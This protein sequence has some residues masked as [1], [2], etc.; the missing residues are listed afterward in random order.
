VVNGSLASSLMAARRYDDAIAQAQRTLAIEPAFAGAYLT[1]GQAHLQ[2]GGHAEAIAALEQAVSLS[3]GLAR[4]VAWL[5]HAY[6]VVGD[7]TKARQVL[8]LLAD[9]SRRA[10]VSPYDVA[11]VHAGLRDT[12]QVFA[13]LQRA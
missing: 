10:P 5:G 13:W 12:E 8:D 7:R 1:L 9:L 4:P 2:R 6:G 11:L 3:P